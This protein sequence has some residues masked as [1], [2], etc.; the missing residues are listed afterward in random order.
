MKSLRL[1]SAL[2][3]TS[4]IGFGAVQAQSPVD[5]LIQTGEM[6]FE[7][8][9]FLFT[10]QGAYNDSGSGDNDPILIRFSDLNND[11]IALDFELTM[12]DLLNAIGEIPDCR[13]VTPEKKIRIIGTILGPSR[14]Q[15]TGSVNP[16]PDWCIKVDFTGVRDC[17]GTTAE[18]SIDTA[19]VIWTFDIVPVDCVVDAAG[20]MLGR[21]ATLQL[22]K[23]GGDA[24]NRVDFVGALF[25]VPVLGADASLTSLQFRAYSGG[26]KKSNGNVNGDCAVN[27]EDLLIVLFNFGTN[28]SGA[29]VNGD[30]QVNDEDLLTVLFNF[31]AVGC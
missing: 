26:V 30:G 18:F 5:C 24:E 29:D 14:V 2:C 15:W 21:K 11:G 7:N 13:A 22:V 9:S 17:V 6:S 20:N 8:N 10:I 28:D 27:D 16:D 4:L 23:F 1:W 25:C 31:G 12:T 19:Q 3:A